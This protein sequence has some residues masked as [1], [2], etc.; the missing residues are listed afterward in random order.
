MDSGCLAPGESLYEDYDVNR[1]LL[2]TEVIGIIDQLLCF[3]VAWHLGYPLSQTLFTSVYI[4]KMVQPA[5][6]TIE[7]ADFI[8]DRPAG[9][10]RDP[11]HAALRAYC[12]GLLKACHYVNEQ[13]KQEHSYEVHR[14]NRRSCHAAG[15]D[16]GDSTARKKTSSLTRTAAR[17][18]RTWSDASSVTRSRLPGMSFAT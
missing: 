12:L 14:I 5:P 8:K 15:T 18:S 17:C 11:M 9:S 2:P 7:E 6:Q 1:P 13:V 4:E 16:I 10:P 3:E